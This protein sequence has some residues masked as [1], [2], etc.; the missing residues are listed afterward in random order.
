MTGD[1]S[2]LA[3]ELIENQDDIDGDDLLT[4][5]AELPE[6]QIDTEAEPSKPQDAEP[7]ETK[8]AD[9]IP[10]PRFD[11]VIAERNRLQAEKDRLQAIIDAQSKPPETTADPV[12]E[13][14]RPY[15]VELD[16]DDAAPNELTLAE[17]QN[18]FIRDV[19][20]ELVEQRQRKQ[21]DVAKQADIDATVRE[22]H[23]ALADVEGVKGVKN[24]GQA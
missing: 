20:G 15:L 9:A 22:Y 1:R 8:P 3:D 19:A 7:E 11:E 12:E 18:K 17:A 16:P 14:I 13:F 24:Q 5:D 6:D 21:V 2:D 4:D 23:G 10:K